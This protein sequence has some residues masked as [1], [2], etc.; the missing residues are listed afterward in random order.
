MHRQP[1]HNAQPH[2]RLPPS[3][4]VTDARMTSQLKVALIRKLRGSLICLAYC[5]ACYSWVFVQP[6]IV[7]Y[8]YLPSHK[9]GNSWQMSGLLVQ[10]LNVCT[11]PFGSVLKTW[12]ITCKG[13]CQ[14]IQNSYPAEKRYCKIEYVACDSRMRIRG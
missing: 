7:L 11:V 14:H 1:G 5:S 12:S 4:L 6:S 3:F 2:T 9:T 13:L 10:E 8:V